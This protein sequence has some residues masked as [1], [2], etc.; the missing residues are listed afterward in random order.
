MLFMEL[1]CYYTINNTYDTY[2]NPNSIH[3]IIWKK[4]KG[5]MMR[6]MFIF[7]FMFFIFLKIDYIR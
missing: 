1:D 2:D 6:F 4:Y 7:G 3:H 5:I